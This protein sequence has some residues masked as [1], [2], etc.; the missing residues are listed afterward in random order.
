ML[1]CRRPAWS[2]VQV[3]F[4][5]FCACKQLPGPLC[6]LPACSPVAGTCSDIHERHR[7]FKRCGR[8]RRAGCAIHVES[9]SC[10]AAAPRPLSPGNRPKLTERGGK[11]F[12]PVLR[13]IYCQPAS[14]R[15]SS[16][17]LGA[18]S[19]LVSV[20]SHAGSDDCAARQPQSAVPAG[21]S[22]LPRQH[23]KSSKLRVLL[24][25]WLGS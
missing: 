22:A 20:A 25:C 19:D 7:F 15:V 5:R 3:H 9:G 2:H 1:R 24:Q 23:T 10:E 16:A 17:E 4:S 12:R 21:S 6:I 8:H 18:G 13:S 14:A 11:A